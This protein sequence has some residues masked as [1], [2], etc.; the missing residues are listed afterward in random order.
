LKASTET[1][2]S[3]ND[4]LKA[5]ENMGKQEAKIGGEAAGAG[6]N[7]TPIFTQ[8]AKDNRK[9]AE[10]AKTAATQYIAAIMR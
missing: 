5:Y 3:A 4:F 10:E 6:L 7:F 2:Q 1:T 8:Y 9:R